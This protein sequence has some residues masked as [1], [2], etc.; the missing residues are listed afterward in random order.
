M[1]R[2]EKLLT[3]LMTLEDDFAELLARELEREATGGHSTYLARKTPHLL[4]GKRYRR[5]DV[6]R[7]EQLER[8]VR[9]LRTQLGEAINTGPIAVLDGYIEATASADSH[10]AGRLTRAA[11][12]ALAQLSKP[13]AS[14]RK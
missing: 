7:I 2:A 14:N 5:P 9:A 11:R 12:L 4:D 10:I 6:G 3:R 13:K 8:Q 1:A